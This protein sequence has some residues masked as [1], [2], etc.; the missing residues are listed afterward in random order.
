M[1]EDLRYNSYSMQRGQFVSETTK[2][3]QDE[4]AGKLLTRLKHPTVTNQLIFFLDEKNFTQDQKV[5]RKNSWWL[6][7]DPTES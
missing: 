5:K 1:Q 4:K 2:A 6:F 7:L 3:W